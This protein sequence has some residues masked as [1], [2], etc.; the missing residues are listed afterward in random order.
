VDGQDLEK[1]YGNTQ[2]TQVF[3]SQILCIIIFYC[4][5]CKTKESVMGQFNGQFVY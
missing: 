3:H 2:E 4:K 1:G 5:M